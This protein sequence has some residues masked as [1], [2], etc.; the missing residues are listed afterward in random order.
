MQNMEKEVR[1]NGGLIKSKDIMNE[2]GEIDGIRSVGDAIP[3]EPEKIKLRGHRA[4]ITKILFH[5]IYT[6]IATSSTESSQS[7]RWPAEAVDDI[8]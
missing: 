3:R 7:R 4:R 8:P 5:P 1:E 6:L 2:N